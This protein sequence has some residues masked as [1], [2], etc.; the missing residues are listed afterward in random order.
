MISQHKNL[1]L[2]I[3]QIV[4]L[5]FKYL[6]N[7]YYFYIIYF[8]VYFNQNY[9]L[10]IITNMMLL[11]YFG[12]YLTKNATY[13]IAKSI[14]LNSNIVFKVKILENQGFDKCSPQLGKNLSNN[15]TLETRFFIL[16][17][18]FIKL[19]L[20]DFLLFLLLLATIFLLLILVDSKVSAD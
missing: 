7:S 13:G 15:K 2:I 8:I 11:V 5:V 9:L 14:N 3:Y 17:T 4:V 12:I 10:K 16:C 18:F 1:T 19:D 6:K 20:V